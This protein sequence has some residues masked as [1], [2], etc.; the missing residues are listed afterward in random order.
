MLEVSSDL[1]TAMEKNYGETATS[2]THGTV[3]S[4]YSTTS[5]VTVVQYPTIVGLRRLVHAVFSHT[6]RL[7]LIN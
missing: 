4:T 3:S 6:H 5:Y 7:I 2:T 1:A